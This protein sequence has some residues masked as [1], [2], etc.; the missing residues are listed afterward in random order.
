MNAVKLVS[1]GIDSYIMSQTI[2]GRNVFIDIGQPYASEEEN[3]LH[4][5]GLDFDVVRIYAPAKFGG[6]MYIPNRNLT[7]ASII[8]MYYNPDK[9]YLAGVRDDICLD[10]GQEEYKRM[11]EILSRYAGKPVQVISP[12]FNKTKGQ[13]IAEYDNKEA[14]KKTFSCYS[15]VNGK[16]CGN[17][18]ACL[19]R[20][21]ALESNGI[22]SGVELSREIIQSYLDKINKNDWDLNKRLIN[23]LLK[24]RGYVLR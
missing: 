6:D 4:E 24:E 8:C 12:F 17:C 2:E 1:G 15:P 3:A 13:I 20:T 18:P 5:L 7:L 14:L 9:I 10:E 22:D 21:I 11:S 19:R 23:H 16:P